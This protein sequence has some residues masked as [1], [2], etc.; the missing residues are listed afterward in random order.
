MDTLDQWLEE[1]K[2]RALSEE[3]LASLLR[4]GPSVL[5]PL[6]DAIHAG[7]RA[8]K[9]NL[10]RVI[11]RMRGAD[12]TPTLI[13]LLEDEEGH[14]RS[15]A[16]EAL[17]RSGDAHAM[18]PLTGQLLDRDKR[19]YD[20]EAAASA[21]G[22]LQLQEAVPALLQVVEEVLPDPEDPKAVAR[23]IARERE[24]SPDDWMA[25]SSRQLRLLIAVLVA[26]VK[27]GQQA[28][29]PIVIDLMGF[30]IEEAPDSS[31][32]QRVREEAIA[33]SVYL[34]GPG[35]LDALRA[36]R[37]REPSGDDVI[38]FGILSAL[39]HLGLRES[40]DEFIDCFADG[41]PVGHS[42]A[43]T[44]GRIAG[45]VGET[46]PDELDALNVWWQARRGRFVPG[47]CYR[48]GQPLD[49]AALVAHL[50]GEL[51]IRTSMLLDELTVI[52][53]ER[54]EPDY[55]LP[56]DRQEQDRIDKA[57]TWAEGNA[58]AFAPGAL[59]KYGHRYE[60]SVVVAA[61]EREDG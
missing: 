24:R 60:A 33:E 39:F 36:A 20:R 52:T 42:P 21:L 45:I 58:Q 11:A 19:S 50:P 27:L 26:L 2:R 59:Y 31:W 41:Y 25:T 34:V 57:Q 17:G 44:L 30:H 4:R 51:P 22:E 40:V 13:P 35:L 3:A 14:V 23:L 32:A 6:L 43:E 28:L 18:A 53:G 10:S 8:Q 5:P 47:V 49:V 15:A 7:A 9:A 37:R 46:P 29:S 16:A 61:K 56:P 12:A 48:W 1:S 55:A 54:F 38:D